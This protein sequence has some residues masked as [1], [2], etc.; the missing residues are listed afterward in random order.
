MSERATDC[1]PKGTERPPNPA[2]MRDCVANRRASARFDQR[3]AAMTLAAP[4]APKDFSSDCAGLHE[5]K[6][7][8]VV[9]EDLRPLMRTA[10]P[11]Q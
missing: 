6:R 8:T 2:Q 3:I 7:Q 5:A 4:T 1:S 11:V 9:S 10:V